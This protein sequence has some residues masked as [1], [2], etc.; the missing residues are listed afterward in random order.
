MAQSFRKII[1][2]PVHGFIS[3]DSK[4]IFEIIAHPY[5]QR[6]RRIRQMALAPL[7]YPGA[8]HTRLLHSLGA[9]H[10]TGLA[11]D[12]LKK[13]G[14]EISKKEEFAVKAAILL[15]D[16]GHGPFS[17]ALEHSL[18]RGVDHEIISLYIMEVL[19]EQMGGKLD[20]A[21]AIFS[22]KYHKPFLHQLISS[23]VDMDRLDYLSRD[24]YFTG[25]SEGVI[26]YDRILQMLA[27]QEDELMI[28]EKGIYS[29]E[30]FLISRRQMYWQVYMHK[31][32]LAAEKMLVRIMR[33]ATEIY[34]DDDLQLK[35][36]GPLD[37]FL[38]GFKGKMTRDILDKFCK[39][40][41][42][43]V[44][45]AVKKWANHPDNVLSKL[46]SMLLNRKL[47]KCVIQSQPI[48]ED[49]LEEKKAIA[50][51]KGLFTSDEID[52]FIF[53]GE[54]TNTTYKPA[55]ENI[56]ILYKN[57]IIKDIAEVDNA[58]ISS[59]LSIPVKKYYICYPK[60]CK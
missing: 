51:K 55:D 10:L 4:D 26:G 47:L 33:R 54:A 56:Q 9:Y 24:S 21:I 52:Y 22:G 43:D 59:T 45:F 14:V 57:G 29:I 18:V 30:K 16:V 37:F 49:L 36:G 8:V 42:N 12:E 46:A 13:K 44:I 15:H 60:E 23:Q 40:D 6:L 25:V 34:H 53:K 19:N 38:K 41:D 1:N 7:V 20:L 35:I 31:T 50:L 11:I 39:L 2:D 5:Y 32:V 58:L 3:I 28:E 27:V 48:D 17:H